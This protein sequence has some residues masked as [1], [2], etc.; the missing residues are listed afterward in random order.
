MEGGTGFDLHRLLLQG[1]FLAPQMVAESLIGADL[2]ARPS[3]ALAFPFSPRR[4]M[5]AAI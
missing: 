5:T 2:V 3:P 4:L 1:L